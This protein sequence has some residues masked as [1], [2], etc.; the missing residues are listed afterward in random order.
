MGMLLCTKMTD[1]SY[2]SAGWY[3]LSLLHFKHYIEVPTVWRNTVFCTYIIQYQ[4]SPFEDLYIIFVFYLIFSNSEVYI[5]YYMNIGQT[6]A[7]GL[8]PFSALIFFNIRIY[9]RFM[10]TRGRF[11]GQGAAGNSQVRSMILYHMQLIVWYNVR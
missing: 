6:V 4:D 11:Q 9:L 8:I 3:L 2:L 1:K 5:K 7:L 10:L